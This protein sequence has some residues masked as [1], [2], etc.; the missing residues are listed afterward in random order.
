MNLVSDDDKV[1]Y[2]LG[3]QDTAKW[4]TP[5]GGNPYIEYS[6][7]IRTLRVTLECADGAPAEFEVLG[8]DPPT[9]YKFRIKHDCACWNKC[10]GG[11]RFT[12]SK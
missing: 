12:R 7:G 6:A 3:T 9:H 2:P 11:R 8:E 1:R 5:L 4:Y 10:G